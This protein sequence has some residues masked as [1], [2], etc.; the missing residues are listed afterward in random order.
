M[1]IRLAF[2]LLSF[3]ALLGADTLLLKNGSIIDGQFV[4]GDGRSI[5][6]TVGNQVN[7][8]NVVDVDSLR[9]GSAS[10]S[11]SNV[12]PAAPPAAY[13]PSETHVGEP[14]ASATPPPPAASSPNG[15]PSNSN[16][17]APNYP[18]PPA[19]ANVPAGNIEVPAGTQVVVRL[20][21]AADSK[22]DSLGQTYR[23][24]VEQPV[25][26]N[27]QTVIPRGSDAVAVLS[28]QQQSGKIEGKTMLT[29]A[30]RSV[31][32]NG[33]TYD[34]A[35]STVNKASTSRSTKS[36]EVIGGTALLGAIIGALAGGGRGAAIG[37]VSGAGVGTA[38][39]IATSGER[40]K[41]PSET[42]LTF[43]LQNP[44]YISSN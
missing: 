36:G 20:I 14:S 29:I 27:G 17:A 37:A 12:P 23:A 28:D 38:A 22:R 24:S 13:F 41:I 42:V 9:F 35:T 16:A 4:G 31:A 19:P 40:V 26:V 6:F 15:P 5:R 33:H 7:T 10:P 25:V 11:A 30:L 39:Q 44:L 18:P 43:A 2:S 21:D 34:L 8:Y 32:V 3:A 1:K